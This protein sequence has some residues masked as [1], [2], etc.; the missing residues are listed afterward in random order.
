VA[1]GTAANPG[2]PF[3]TKMFDE[4][5]NLTKPWITF[6]QNT[7]NGQAASSSSAGGALA[8][9]F[10]GANGVV[11]TPFAGLLKASGGA[12][13]YTYS[14]SSGT[15][16]A[17]LALDPATGAITGTPTAVGASTFTAQVTDSTSTT[18]TEGCS[19][20]ISAATTG[21]SS[22][23]PGTVSDVALS[24]AGPRVLYPDAST[25]TL[26]QM[27]PTITGGTGL[28]YLAIYLSFDSG[29]TWARQG[30][31]PYRLGTDT[32]L[33]L[34]YLIRTKAECGGLTADNLQLYVLEGEIGG[35]PNLMPAADLPVGGVFSNKLTVLLASPLATGPTATLTNA[36][37][38]TATPSNIYMGFNSANNPYCSLVITLT[39]GS[40]LDP[41]T[42]FYELTC[43]AVDADGNP[44]SPGG[45][46]HAPGEIE[47][48]EFPNDGKTRSYTL[49]C[50]YPAPGSPYTYLRLKF[51]GINRDNTAVP[52]FT[53]SD[54]TATLL[55]TCWGGASSATID[56]IVPPAVS[57]TAGDASA[58]D[59]SDPKYAARYASSDGQRSTM[60]KVWYQPAI[61]GDIYPCTVAVFWNDGTGSGWHFD[62]TVTVTGA[63]QWFY[64]SGDAWVPDASQTW[65]IAALA[66]GGYNASYNAGDTLPIGSCAP[67]SF[68]L[69]GLSLPAADLIT[70]LTISPPFAGD[71]PDFP[72]NAIDPTSGYQVFWF[73]QL[74]F[75]DTPALADPNAFFTGLTI[76]GLDASGNPC[77][78]EAMVDS[79][80]VS[81]KVENIG[82][83][84]GGYGLHGGPDRTASPAKVRFRLWIGNRAAPV[85][86]AWNDPAYHTQQMAIGGGL[87]YVD[88]LVAT[89]GQLPGPGIPATQ[90]D[91]TTLGSGVNK[92][93]TTGNL[94][95]NYSPTGPL[96]DDGTGAVTLFLSAPLSVVDKTVMLTEAAAAALMLSAQADGHAI[97][98]NQAVA[99][100]NMAAAAI[101]Y[102]NAAL[103]ALAVVDANMYSV[104][105]NKVTYGTS[106]F[107]GP[108]VLCRGNNYPLI[109]LNYDSI[110]LFSKCTASGTAGAAG[111]SAPSYSAAGLTTAP[112]LVLAA[113][114]LGLFSGGNPA[115]TL[116]AAALTFW[117]VNGNTGQ[118]YAQMGYGG[119]IIYAGLFTS[120]FG[121]SYAQ[122]SVAGGPSMTLFPTS[123]TL[124][125]GSSQMSLYAT[126]LIFQSGA[127]V[128]NITNNG[129]NQFIQLWTSATVTAGVVTGD[130]TKPYLVFGSIL[131][132]PTLT[133]A[134]G[135]YS[136]TLSPYA[137]QL[138]TT[139]G[140]IQLNYVDTIRGGNSALGIN[141]G[142]SVDTLYVRAAYA[143]TLGGA[144]APGVTGLTPSFSDGTNIIA[145]GF[146][147]G[148]YI[149]YSV[150]G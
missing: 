62:Q 129:T 32:F 140:T 68:V 101:T 109:Y 30:Y 13:P 144:Y 137:L 149:G 35:G 142:L 45:V 82:P 15:L 110:T 65:Q 106:I 97:L 88:V 38:E 119:F 115:A 72:Y 76:Q 78:P 44:G 131:G 120:T 143:K 61:E 73:D 124:Q 98:A 33:D 4:N 147:Q 53:A 74:S 49:L 122:L 16:P 95:L 80:L 5:G 128:L 139:A 135:S 59:P 130:T 17:G 141:G 14:L 36:Q 94:Q 10:T 90:I 116:T 3:R 19:I 42:W 121:A 145:L 102:G 79:R 56:E 148:L 89:G 46:D 20:T 7:G 12:E 92:N 83:V 125:A 67:A 133:M 41:N 29:S 81:G 75:D 64:K 104:A 134:A 132:T 108:V 100:N 47:V 86:N 96:G 118:P 66:T 113:G 1:K 112:Y 123:L 114:S 22:G 21:S 26:L 84:K 8:L 18:A 127:Y 111:S 107:A 40:A 57:I 52:A 9:V 103:G 146:A 43:E 24:E 25:H 87:G 93:P 138:A 51:Y 126:G 63:D 55:T 37:G 60:T 34:D 39:P 77:A 54:G 105:M 70:S 50:N 2:V 99:A 6:F 117:S 23:T 58:L 48:N 31:W 85:D 136:L 91:P 11:G 28:Q 27:A 69:A 150:V 71:S